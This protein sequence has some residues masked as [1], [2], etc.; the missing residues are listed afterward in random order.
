MCVQ[1]LEVLSSLSTCYLLKLTPVLLADN[2]LTFARTFAE[3]LD[4]VTLNAPKNQGGFF[5]TGLNGNIK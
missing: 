4:I 5:P 2:S 1:M 3:V